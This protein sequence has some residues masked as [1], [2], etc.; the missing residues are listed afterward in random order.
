MFDGFRAHR[1]WAQMEPGR[2]SPSWAIS[3]MI[4]ERRSSRTGRESDIWASIC[5]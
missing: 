4:W 5:E 1:D 2:K 3:K